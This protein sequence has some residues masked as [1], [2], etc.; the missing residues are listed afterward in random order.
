[1]ASSSSSSS[2][3]IRFHRGGVFALKGG[4]LTRCRRVIGLMVVFENHNGKGNLLSAVGRDGNNQIYPIAWAV[5]S[6]E[7]K[8]NW[9][10]FMELLISDLGLPSGQGLTIISDQHNG[11]IEAAKQVMPMAEHRQCARH[12]YANFRKKYTGVLYRNL[13]WQAAKA[14]YPTMFEKVMKEIQCINKDA[15]KHLMDRHPESWSRAYF[16]TDKACDAVENGI[17]ECFNA[18]IVDDRRKPI[19]NMLEDI[20]LLCMDR[21]QRMREKHEKWN[22][23]ICPNIKKK[24]EKC[25]DDHRFWK[26][27]ASGQTSFEVRNGY[28][29]FKVNERARTCTCRG[30]QLSGIPCVH[31]IAAIYFLHKDP[32]NYVSQ[33]PLPPIKRRMP[34]RPPHKRKRDAMEDDGGNRTRIRS[35][36]T[37]RGGSVTAKGGKVTVRGGK[38]TASGG[39]V[40]ASGGIVSARGGNASIRGGKVS[41]QVGRKDSMVFQ[42]C[43]RPEE[44]TITRLHIL[45]LLVHTEIA[46]FQSPPVESQEQEAPMQEQPVQEQPLQEQ[47][48]PRVK[49]EPVQ[50]PCQRNQKICT[51]SC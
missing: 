22:D 6:V 23:G 12:I 46:I 51:K 21:S 33:Q 25:K 7:N 17:S 24:L 42:D 16:T 3:L 26:V 50:T 14:T 20:R 35:K 30:W 2:Y 32:E 1:M 45:K 44:I 40:S 15:Y 18:L 13:F 4:L 27:I 5:V 36:V 31:G 43:N 28:E 11:I 29:G 10:W 39:N 49:G 38:V 8:D 37:A 34:G 19:I 48:V 47:P 9:V 41:A